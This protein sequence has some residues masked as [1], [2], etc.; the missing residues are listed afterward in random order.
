MEDTQDI[1]DQA[2]L[3]AGRA[4]PKH[5]IPI[6]VTLRKAIKHGMNIRKAPPERTWTK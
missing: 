2:S 4:R 3:S 6:T 1:E 5:A